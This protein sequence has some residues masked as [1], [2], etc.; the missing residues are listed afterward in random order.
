M[1][2]S[3]P[4]A[5]TVCLLALFSSAPA[6]TIALVDSQGADSG[7]DLV[8]PDGFG[9]DVHVDAVGDG[10]VALEIAKAFRDAP[11][12]GVFATNTVVFQ[13][14]L[15]DAATVGTI[16]IMN[17]SITNLTGADW[18][19]YHWKVEGQ[20]AFN[21][22]LTQASGW[23]VSPFTVV[24]WDLFSVPDYAHAAVLNVSGGVVADGQTFI[25]GLTGGWLQIDADLSEGGLA[26]FW[27]SQTPT[28]EPATM[29]LLAL[30]GAG[31]LARRRR[32][33]GC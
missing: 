15:S 27:F 2:L 32:Q 22:T 13:Q 23:G 7:W 10:Y 16:Y 3:A 33:D 1:R 18:T 5:L 21:R 12:N 25:P 20:A 19:D 4:A 31:L 24:E 8:V 29:A 11:V 30:G 9:F 26:E 17:E 28:P 14:R 6:A